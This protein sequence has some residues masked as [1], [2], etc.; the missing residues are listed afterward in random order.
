VKTYLTDT[1]NIPL[2]RF[3]NTDVVA[4]VA[5]FVGLKSAD[6]SQCTLH[7]K[8]ID[9]RRNNDIK[10]ACSFTFSTEK[11]P[12]NAKEYA[13][14]TDI[15]LDVNSPAS[16]RNIIIV[17]SGPA[18]L[19]AARYL[20]RCGHHVTIVE[21]GG[22][23]DARIA[24]VSTFFAGGAL[25]ENCNIQ[26][27]LGGA[28]T[29]SDGKLTTGISSPYTYTVFREFVRA[30]A[31]DEIMHSATP[32]IGTENLR[33]VVATLRDNIKAVGGVFLFDS[34]VS[35]VEIE[36][37]RTTNVHITHNVTRKTSILSC[38][39]VIFAV[40]HSARDTFRMLSDVGVN[41]VSK[42]F[43]VGVRVEHTRQF[44]S[45]RQYGAMWA[46]HRDLRSA[47]YKLAANF[48]NG[49]SC[50]SFCMCPGG[51]VVA[52][53]SEQGGVVVNGM[54]NF[55]RLADNSNSALVVNVTA[56]DLA[57]VFSMEWNFSASW[58]VRHFL[59]PVAIS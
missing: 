3:D 52:A 34:T 30:G 45:S 46:T 9:A 56:N 55:D 23:I 25:D 26:F 32:H 8:S 31:P 13:F 14:P 36:H 1:I 43:A 51:T 39:D 4:V 27:G 59:Q 22:D 58:K 38:D 28:G 37:N 6:I 21:R 18:G 53:A 33:T 15:L 42:P 10:F 54:S 19:F 50:Y 12:K 48:D 7:K 41:I 40:G 20:T 17:G 5:H 57:A 49:R 47:S 24:A 16:P 29:F 2:A 11:Q 35:S 44:V